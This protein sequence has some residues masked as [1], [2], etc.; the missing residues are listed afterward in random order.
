MWPWEARMRY[1][2]GSMVVVL[3]LMAG[4]EMVSEKSGSRLKRCFSLL[5]TKVCSSGKV[6]CIDARRRQRS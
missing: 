1:C 4:G 2:E 3:A 6:T 5:A